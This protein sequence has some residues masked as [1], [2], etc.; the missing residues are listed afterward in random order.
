M[1]KLIDKNSGLA[2]YMLL[3]G[4]VLNVLSAI[5][6]LIYL[7]GG[8]F[9]LIPVLYLLS[10]VMA[11][12]TIYWKENLLSYL[13]YFLNLGG[14][15]VYFCTESTQIVT[16]VTAVETSSFKGTFILTTVFV[17][18]SMVVTFIATFSRLEKKET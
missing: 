3:A 16:A 15:A 1:N 17:V 12:V 8:S 5:S 11:A 4:V 14:L 7:G 2:A 18:L 10:A 9:F 6:Y 13:A